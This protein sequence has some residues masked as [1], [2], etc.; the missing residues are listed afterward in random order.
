MNEYTFSA[1]DIVELKPNKRDIYPANL[2]DRRAL[3]D[4]SFRRPGRDGTFEDETVRLY[5]LHKTSGKKL[6][7][8]G[9][10]SASVLQKAA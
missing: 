9:F 3:V 10:F 2:R 4:G 1:G 8:P 5:W 7:H 6:G